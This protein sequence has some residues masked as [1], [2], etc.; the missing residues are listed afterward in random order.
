MKKFGDS[1]HISL[2]KFGD[3][4]PFSL[5]NSVFTTKKWVYCEITHEKVCTIAV[6]VVS[7]R[8]QVCIEDMIW[9]SMLN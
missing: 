9:K 1:V 8:H 2:N 4:S 5:K 7:L 3:F 6:I